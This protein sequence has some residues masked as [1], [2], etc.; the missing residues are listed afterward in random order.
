MET[1]TQS[2]LIWLLACIS[3]ANVLVALAIP[4]SW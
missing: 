2:Q 4:G 1:M 3:F